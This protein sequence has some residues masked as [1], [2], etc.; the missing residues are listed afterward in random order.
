APPEEPAPPPEE[1]PADAS[2]SEEPVSN[3]AEMPVPDSEDV[4]EAVG[5]SPLA[6]FK[7]KQKL[8][9]LLVMGVV[10]LLFLVLMIAVLVGA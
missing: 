2:S 5:N 3:S 7:D 6:A 8:V 9:P 4:N 1:P 10:G